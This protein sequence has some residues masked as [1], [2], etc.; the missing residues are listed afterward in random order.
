VREAPL[1]NRRGLAAALGRVRAGGARRDRPPLDAAARGAEAAPH[2][3]GRHG[4]TSSSAVDG[5]PLRRPPARASGRGRDRPPPRVLRPPRLRRRPAARGAVRPGRRTPS[6]PARRPGPDP[7]YDVSPATDARPYFHRF[8]RWSRLGDLLERDAVPFVEWGF[9]GRPR[10][11]RARS[12]ASPSPCS[13]VARP[14]ARGPAPAPTFSCSAWASCCSRWPPRP[15]HGEARQPP[16]WPR[17]PCW[18]GSSSVRGWGASA[19][20][21]GAAD[22]LRPRPRRGPPRRPALLLLPIAPCRSGS[23]RPRRVPDGLP[24]PL[25]LSRL[26]PSSVPWPSP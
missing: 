10:R 23:S 22:G 21:A 6:R 5:P 14:V 1:L 16:P 17:R 26:A 20:S 18:A 4:R 19:A 15:G 25:R 11:L 12:C 7:P 3:R 8:F 24:L 13:S 9:V 2:R